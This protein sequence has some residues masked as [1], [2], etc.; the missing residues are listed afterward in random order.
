MIDVRLPSVR[1]PRVGA[2][3]PLPIEEQEQRGHNPVGGKALDLVP[4]EGLWVSG[5]LR[6]PRKGPYLT[7]G[8]R[9]GAHFNT[10]GCP[11]FPLREVGVLPLLYSALSAGSSHRAQVG[12]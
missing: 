8:M 9:F 1:R 7:L 6:S 2:T 10:L 3:P 4:R 5:L 11:Y 12:L